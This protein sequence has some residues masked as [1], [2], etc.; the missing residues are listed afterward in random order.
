MP[1]FGLPLLS[2]SR[3]QAKGQGQT[4]PNLALHVPTL[5]HLGTWTSAA[6]HSFK[7]FTDSGSF[8]K[9]LLDEVGA[10]ELDGWVGFEPTLTKPARRFPP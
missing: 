2:G 8:F 5:T 10:A 4:H 9:N 7:N 6:A 1:F 3:N